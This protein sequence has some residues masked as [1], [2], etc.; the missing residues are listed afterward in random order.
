MT[1]D[2]N[3]ELW[4]RFRAACDRFFTRRKQDL[5]ERKHQWSDNLKR[6][7][8]ICARAEELATSPDWKQASA[9]LKRLQAEW[10]TIGPVKRTK[11]EALWRRFRAA[12]DTFFE[13]YKN[14]D[15]LALADGVHAREALCAEMEA[16]AAAPTPE[17]EAPAEL[18]QDL[19]SAALALW[20]RWMAA[21]RVPRPVAEPVE[22]R[23]EGALARLL[24]AHPARFKGTRLD[25]EATTRRMEQLCA[26]V[27]G[28]AAAQ[29][30]GPDLATAP[31]QALAS[32]LKDA[33]AAN[34]IGGRVDDEAKRRAA[35][36]AVRDAQVAWR[37]LGPV[38]G[39]RARA[40]AARFHRACRR[41]FE[42][43][44]PAAASRRHPPA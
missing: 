19:A 12:C 2:R 34:T 37:R 33:L 36:T 5:A 40:L 23:F 18:P 13:R 35:V 39:E 15:Q 8:A 42:Q 22:Q 25:V 27:E 1:Q 24:E 44:T 29:V 3:R 10:K 4:S 38:P 26:Q 20:E 31:A 32:L 14:R 7:E 41:F 30:P 43:A 6:K 11:S 28:L 17:G 9:E 16:L 21:P